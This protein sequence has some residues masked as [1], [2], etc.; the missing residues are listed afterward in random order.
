MLIEHL[1]DCVRN[2]EPPIADAYKARH[3]LEIMT[4]A[5]ESAKSD[6]VVELATSF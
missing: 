2:G 5:I 4:A 3:A 1:I 6:R